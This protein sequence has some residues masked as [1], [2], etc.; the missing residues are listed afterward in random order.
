MFKSTGTPIERFLRFI[1]ISLNGCWEWQGQK[2]GGGYGYFW[3]GEKQVYAHRFSFQTYNGCIPLD[4][5]ID[6]L[7]RNKV[8]VNPDHLEV[9]THLTNV[10]RGLAGINFRMK[11][12]CPK[13]HPY[14]KANTYI[15]PKGG[16]V[17]RQCVR[18][19]YTP[20][21]KRAYHRQVPLKPF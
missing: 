4:F 10:K 13:G 8:C 5:E 16:R 18:E 3:N 1:V 11:M 17:C 7:C 20:G 2:A 12:Y 15:P 9:V 19:R 6:H 14:I 21:L